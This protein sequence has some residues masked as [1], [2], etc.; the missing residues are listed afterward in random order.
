[1]PGNERN[2][3]GETAAAIAGGMA[4]TLSLSAMSVS[5]L[6]S[7][8]AAMSQPYIQRLAQK[9]LEEVHR[10]FAEAA[11][12]NPT[13][14]ENHLIQSP[15]AAKLLLEVATETASTTYPPKVAALSE[16]LRSGALREEGV[17]LDIEAHVIRL[18][19]KLER[20]HVMA[21][22]QIDDS[23]G[24]CTSRSLKTT[25]TET[26]IVLDGIIQELVHY[27]L[28]ETTTFHKGDGEYA[29]DHLS[30]TDLGDQIINRYRSVA[31]GEQ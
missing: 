5:P 11:G 13:Q 23:T 7:I 25:N 19:I 15:P 30:L 8:P 26:A 4:A 3:H 20:L 14:L 21:L 22:A 31:V 17:K 28:L 9:T 10:L 27:G 1:M 18:I 24:L 12:D 29:L 16:A 2:S 6:L